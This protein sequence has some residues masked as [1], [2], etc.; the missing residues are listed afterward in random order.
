[1]GVFIGKNHTIYNLTRTT[2]NLVGSLPLDGGYFFGLFALNA[3][4]IKDLKIEDINVAK[5]V[6][7]NII[8]KGTVAIWNLET[9]SILNCKIEIG[10][11]GFSYSGILVIDGEIYAINDGTVNNCVVVYID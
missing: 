11:S 6:E 3:G 10:T 5:H 2:N 4:T 1:M 8:M 7:A 9:G